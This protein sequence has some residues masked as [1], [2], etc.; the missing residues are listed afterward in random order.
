MT[1]WRAWAWVSFAWMSDLCS[2]S[3]CPPSRSFHTRTHTH[4]HTHAART[5]IPLGDQ[6]DGGETRTDSFDQSLIV[7]CRGRAVCGDE[8]ARLSGLWWGGGARQAL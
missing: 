2:L 6:V 4:T 5:H 7:R 1:D 8:G 3:A